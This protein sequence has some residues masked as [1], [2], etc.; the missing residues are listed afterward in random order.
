MAKD[1]LHALERRVLG[2]LDLPAHLGGQ[3]PSSLVNLGEKVALETL[4]SL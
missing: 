4:L 1:R 3:L 2:Q